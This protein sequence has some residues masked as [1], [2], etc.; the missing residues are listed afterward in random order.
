MTCPTQAYN[1]PEP[2]QLFSLPDAQISLWPDWLDNASQQALMLK[3]SDELPWSQDK[4]KLFGKSVLIPRRQVWMGDAHCQYQYSGT[5]FI[6][7]HWHSEVSAITTQ[8]SKFL[9]LPFN[10]VL[11]NY[12][13]DG[14]QHMGW[15]ADNEPELGENPYI[16]S[17]SLGALRRF[18]LK[19]RHQ[20]HQLSIGL[21][22][23]SL[24]L[25]AGRC[26]QAWVHRIPKQSRVTA[27]RINLTFRYIKP[28]G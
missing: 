26:Q 4:I 23:G 6:P 9:M 21:A 17:L 1:R 22:G 11:L 16:A 12:Y 5:R 19:H 18:D 20:E 15:H 28:D 14:A 24:L 7:Q 27:P 13:A 2:P 8:V 10:C 25:M 3:L